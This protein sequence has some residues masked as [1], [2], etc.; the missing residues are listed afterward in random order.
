ME[1]QLDIAKNLDFLKS[2]TNYFYNPGNYEYSKHG[3]LKNI[4]LDLGNN[5]I[6][7]EKGEHYF[8]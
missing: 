5:K 7:N 6:S 2:F 1:Y 4:N 8:F 3:L